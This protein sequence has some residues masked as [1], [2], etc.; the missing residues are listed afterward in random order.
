MNETW[1]EVQLTVPAAGVDLVGQVLMELGSQGIVTAERKLDT[2]IPPDPDEPVQ[3]DQLLRAYFPP[4]ID[5]AQ[6]RPAIHRS[7]EEIGVFLPDW[8]PPEPIFL[9]VRQEDWAEGWKQ[10]FHAFRVGPLVVKPSWEEWPG[11]P[12]DLVM[13][14]DPGMAFGTGTHAT[15]RLCLEALVEALAMLPPGA[16]VLDVGT[17]SGI[18]AIAA[19]RL[20]ATKIVACDIDPEAC[21]VAR[22]NAEQNSVAASIEFT[23]RPLAEISGRYQIVLANILAEENIRL[24]G[25][26]V[27][28]LDAGGWL[29]L[30]GIL[31][32]KESLVCQAFAELGLVEPQVRREGEWIALV[33]QIQS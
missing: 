32:E 8:T 26:L 22:G 9:P 27:A 28:R 18:L 17:G 10:H 2:F 4:G 3:G 29:V 20:G 24:A 25:S 12:Q 6:L 15:T 19:A 14:I 23:D 1:L 30:S 16:A 21:R 13:E 11:T 33:Y 5:A 31:A 7:L